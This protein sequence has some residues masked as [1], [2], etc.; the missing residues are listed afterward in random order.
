M[1]LNCCITA[2]LGL[3]LAFSAAPPPTAAETRSSREASTL[4][5]RYVI[6]VADD[7]VVDV[8]HN[9][10]AV[11]DA[12]RTLLE[13][14]FG[15]TAERL[16]IEV[17]KGDW[18]VFNVV[19]NRIR[20]DGVHY[21]AAAGCFAPNEFGFQSDLTSGQWSACDSPREA[22]RFIEERDHLRHRGVKLVSQPWSDGT[23]LMRSLAGSE[24]NGTPIWGGRRNTWIKLVVE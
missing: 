4:R 20:W 18:L 11:P 15:A 14:R 2:A 8:F 5:A 21:F 12:K 13:E 1:R 6:T 9:G 10:K 16:N 24:W 23:P 7:F 3:L 17:R 22:D 19:N